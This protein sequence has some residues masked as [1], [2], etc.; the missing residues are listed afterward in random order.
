MTS[1]QGR[2]RI[3]WRNLT[4]IEEDVLVASFITAVDCRVFH[5]VFHLGDPAPLD[6]VAT[7]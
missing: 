5:F 6:E 2:T 7:R 3:C 4:W 1:Q